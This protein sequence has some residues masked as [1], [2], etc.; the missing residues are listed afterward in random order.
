MRLDAD[1]ALLQPR[2]R[3]HRPALDA[4]AVDLVVQV[5][6][7][8]VALVADLGD[9]VARVHDLAGLDVVVAHVAVDVDVPVGVL[10]V[11]RVAEAGGAPG[12]E[13]HPVGRRVDRGAER[14]GQVEAVVH[15]APAH[16]VA[17]GEAALRGEHGLGRAGRAGGGELTQPGL[18]LGLGDAA[19]HIRVVDAPAERDVGG[20]AQ[21]VVGGVPPGTHRAADHGRGPGEEGA[22]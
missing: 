8:R 3:V 20:G 6:P 14:G 18:R 7:G 17:G 1:P 4:A 5:R 22:G 13:D 15:L 12:P 16:A 2:L 21:A 11:H 19:A 9:L 10:D